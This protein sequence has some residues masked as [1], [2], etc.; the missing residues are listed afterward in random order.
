[1][2]ERVPAA[3]AANQ[4]AESVFKNIK[5]LKGIPA[6]RVVNIIE[7]ERPPGNRP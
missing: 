2:S 5:I 1:M 3:I 6:G 7:P 4:P